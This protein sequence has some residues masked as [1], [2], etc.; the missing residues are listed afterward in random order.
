MFTAGEWAQLQRRPAASETQA[1]LAEGSVILA[2][3]L[4]Q[5][6]VEIMRASY[7]N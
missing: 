2:Q 4:S 6:V 1:K 7:E 5:A 3:C